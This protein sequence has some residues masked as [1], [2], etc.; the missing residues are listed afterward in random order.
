[1][2][3]VALGDQDI[4]LSTNQPSPGNCNTS[5]YPE[6]VRA[7]AKRTLLMV[8]F[9]KIP[10]ILGC[11]ALFFLGTHFLLLDFGAPPSQPCLAKHSLKS[12]LLMAYLP[13]VFFRLPKHVNFVL[14]GSMIHPK[15]FPPNKWNWHVPKS[16]LFWTNR[17][18]RKTLQEKFH[19][20]ARSLWFTG[21]VF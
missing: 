1:M 16:G 6:I 8:V 15:N 10:F 9:G 3:A 21:P 12:D 5:H 4:F 20:F 19:S 17:N 7:N 11:S 18:E 14:R 13:P 2:W